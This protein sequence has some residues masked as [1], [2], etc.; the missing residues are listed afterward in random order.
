MSKLSSAVPLRA[1]ILLAALSLAVYFLFALGHRGAQAFQMQNEGA[2][3]EREI[4]R[5]ESRHQRLEADREA[6]QTDADIE[7]VAREQLNL[8]KPGE[9]AVIVVPAEGA[10]ARVAEGSS[11]PPTRETDSIPWWQRL[12]GR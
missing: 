10:R 12:L 6:S 5:L 11:E 9:T 2:Q 3:L 8:I 1:L 4:T 7:K